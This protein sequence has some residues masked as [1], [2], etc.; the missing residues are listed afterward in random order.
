MKLIALSLLLL[1]T[2][3]FALVPVPSDA[4]AQRAH[5][6]G[7]CGSLGPGSGLRD[8]KG[9]IVS[10][11]PGKHE[12]RMR[13]GGTVYLTVAK[14]KTMDFDAGRPYYIVIEGAPPNATLEWKIPGS[15]WGPVSKYFLYPPQGVTY[16][17]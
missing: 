2:G 11:L 16:A 15:D 10:M 9:W 17:R 5:A 8:G 13:G 14:L 1:N 3:A 6:V 12:L 4:E 7:S